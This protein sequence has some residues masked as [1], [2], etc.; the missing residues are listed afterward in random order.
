MFPVPVSEAAHLDLQHSSALQ[1]VAAD[2]LQQVEGG[3]AALDL[4]GWKHT[5]FVLEHSAGL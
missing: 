5:R 4:Q 2:L 3:G 1:Q